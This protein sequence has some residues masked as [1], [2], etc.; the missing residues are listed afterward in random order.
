MV[1]APH[2]VKNKWQIKK[3]KGL[4]SAAENSN[5]AG[6]NSLT[7]EVKKISC[8]FNFGTIHYV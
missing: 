1:S 6:D 5:S 2:S 3:K 4:Y 8:L 7:E